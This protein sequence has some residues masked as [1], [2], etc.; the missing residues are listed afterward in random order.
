MKKTR[1]HPDASKDKKGRLMVGAAVGVVGDYL[2]RAAALLTAGADVLV[3]DV[4]H[5]HAEHVLG[6]GRAHQEE[7]AEAEVVA[8]NVATFEGAR[9]LAEAGADGIKVGSARAPSAR[10]AS[11]RAPACLN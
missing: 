1:L 10:P 4:A 11:S 9:D 2:D 7:V 3:V 5:G 6:R 8:G